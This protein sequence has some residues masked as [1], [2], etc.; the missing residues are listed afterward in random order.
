MQLQSSFDGI[1]FQ[2]LYLRCKPKMSI[3]MEVT[4][5]EK[6]IIRPYFDIITSRGQKVKS[7]GFFSSLLSAKMMP[8]IQDFLNIKTIITNT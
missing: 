8:N 6:T 5:D 3:D 1:H 2:R 4:E 7:W